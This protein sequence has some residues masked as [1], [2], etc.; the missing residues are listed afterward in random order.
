[1]E[2]QQKAELTARDGVLFAVGVPLI[3]AG[4]AGFFGLLRF[5]RWARPLSVFTS[6]AALLGLPFFGPTVEPG[7]TT[8]LNQLASMS[9]GAVLATAYFSPTVNE[10]FEVPPNKPL[11]PTSGGKIEGK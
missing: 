7:L 1:L 2:Q 6:A 11:Q 8:A 3:V 5:S 9:Y 4:F 10:W